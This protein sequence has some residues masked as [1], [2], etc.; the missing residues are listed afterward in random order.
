MKFLTIL[1]Q[2]IKSIMSNK[3]RSF[4][5]V[6]GIIIGIGSVI[7]LMSLGAG[8]QE[9]ISKEI[10]SLGSTNLMITS[11]VTAYS[12]SSYMSSDEASK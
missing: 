7:G 1:K 10:N 6:L 8:V 4:L 11:G 5:T 9:S 2:S 3:V 12:K